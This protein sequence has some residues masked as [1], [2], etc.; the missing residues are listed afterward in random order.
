MSFDRQS[1]FRLGMQAV[2]LGIISDAA[3]LLAVEVWLSDNERSLEEVL[4]SQ[5]AT[6]ISSR[7]AIAEYFAK[8][9]RD[10][11]RNATTPMACA[12]DEEVERLKD[13]LVGLTKT[14]LEKEDADQEPFGDRTAP[15][16]PSAN[17]SLGT[18]L[19]GAEFDRFRIVERHAH[20]GLGVIF[21]AKDLQLHRTVAVKK[22]RASQVDLTLARDKFL[23]EAEVT[24]NLEHPGIVPVYALGLDRSQQPFYAMR[25]IHGENL[26]VHIR[27]FHEEEGNPRSR[28]RFNGIEFR[29]LLRRFL[30]VCNAMEYAHARGILHRDLKPAN[31]MLGDHGETLVVDWGLAKVMK[32]AAPTP[33]ESQPGTSQPIVLQ[34]SG[35]TDATQFGSFLGTTAYASPEQLMGEVD[36]LC[37]RSDVYS[38]GV[39]LYELLCGKSALGGVK[40]QGEA[41]NRI[42]NRQITPLRAIQKGVPKPL[43]AICRK[44]MSFDKLERY[45]SAR[46]LA[47]DVERWLADDRVL[48]YRREPILEF[49]GRFVRRNKSWVLAI[50][51]AL[52]IV[53]GVSI[54]ASYLISR[55]RANEV[56]AK[57]L[58]IDRQRSTN[59]AIDSFLVG[60]ESLSDFPMIVDLQQRT[61]E[62]AAND[63]SKLVDTDLSD[64][65]LAV[66]RMRATVRLAD[67]LHMQGN[68]EEAYKKYDAAIAALDNATPSRRQSSAF[69]DTNVEL[70]LQIELGRVFARKGLALDSDGRSEEAKA[71]YERAIALYRETKFRSR[72]N[73][74]LNGNLAVA[75]ANLGGLEERNGL[76]VEAISHLEASLPLFESA[77]QRARVVFA[78]LGAKQASDSVGLYVSRAIWTPQNRFSM[79]R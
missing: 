35:S 49:A 5:E 12:S 53:S 17:S 22:I 14:E 10:A 45:P 9:K 70:G 42:K 15:Y 65:E 28:A 76:F 23:L 56:R 25:F 66:E 1:Q 79:P 77:S 21:K 26:H 43:D 8:T 57:K 32:Q 24:G 7:Q 39:I 50:C 47:T 29:K 33:T 3:F 6:P 40:S 2:Q 63:Y 11:L 75:L 20:G 55:S 58:A 51:T 72:D 19:V 67:F 46:E 59:A 34:L 4:C 68:R 71:A 31:V 41:Y 73:P 48:A 18:S 13:F 38:L 69:A 52:L 64:P 78:L 27:K 60:T 37:Q 61:L 30:D 62:L 74:W 54:S 44:A 16:E 36:A